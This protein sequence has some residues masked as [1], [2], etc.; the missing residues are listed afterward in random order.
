MTDWYQIVPI[1]AGVS[2]AVTVAIRWFDRP[3]AVLRLEGRLSPTFDEHLSSAGRVTAHASLINI[4]DGDA[5]DVRLYGSGCD[6]VVPSRA[7][8]L[9]G[10][11]PLW[12]HRLA[13]VRAGDTVR[14]TVGVPK[15]LEGGEALIVTWSPSPK[16]WLRKT[17]RF[18]FD[19]LPS[20]GLFPP[21]VMPT[22]DIPKHVR[23]T[24]KLEEL[25]PRAN[26]TLQRDDDN[27]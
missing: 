10:A 23:R 19:Q 26:H 5:F 22:V 3:R 18:E 13:V 8:I 1:A 2:A 21:S 16:R 27:L 7:D 6:A 11:P 17:V 20:E 4:G 15:P 14:L 25:S 24:K 12:S 9:E